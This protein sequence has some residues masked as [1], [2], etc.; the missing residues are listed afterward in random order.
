LIGDV[1]SDEILL[2]NYRYAVS[3]T[4]WIIWS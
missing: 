3:W 1:T 4:A 2:G